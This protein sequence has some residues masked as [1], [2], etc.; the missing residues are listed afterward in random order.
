M[1][2]PKFCVNCVNFSP[3]VNHT[4]FRN[5]IEFGK[6]LRTHKFELVSGNSEYRFCTIERANN[7]GCGNDGVYFHLRSE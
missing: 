1:D 2:I 6:C 3:D 4:E 7:L 5:Q